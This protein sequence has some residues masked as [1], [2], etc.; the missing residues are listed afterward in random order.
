MCESSGASDAS[1]GGIAVRVLDRWVTGPRHPSP[2]WMLSPAFRA[3]TLAAFY[4]QY[5]VCRTRIGIT[6]EVQ[7]A[8]TLYDYLATV[9]H[10]RISL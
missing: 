9:S 6:R 1:V 3:S 10:C 2:K 7:V 5:R 8:I 4:A